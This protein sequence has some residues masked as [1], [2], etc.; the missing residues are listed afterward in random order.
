QLIAIDSIL[1]PRSYM[2][3]TDAISNHIA[4]EAGDV[5]EDA[6]TQTAFVQIREIGDA[7]ADAAARNPNPFITL[8]D[9]PVDSASRVAYGLL[10]R[11]NGASKIGADQVIGSW[12]L[13]ISFFMVGQR[14]T[15]SRIA[16][17]IQNPAQ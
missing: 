9:K 5:V 11:G 6:Y 2:A 14:Q 8:L 17:A 3:C 15:Q 4:K 12:T 1:K 7:G 13:R 16:Q 10:N